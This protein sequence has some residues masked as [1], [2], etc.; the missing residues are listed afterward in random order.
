MPKILTVAKTLGLCSSVQAFQ[1]NPVS[2][3]RSIWVLTYL[4]NLLFLPCL[5]RNYFLDN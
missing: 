1:L 4:N 3:V 5:V 2:F